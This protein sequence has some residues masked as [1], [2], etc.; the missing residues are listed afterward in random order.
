MDRR[1]SVCILVC[2][3][4][5][6]TATPAVWAQS[7]PVALN[8][9]VSQNW[10][11]GN[12]SILPI[13]FAAWNGL[14]RNEI[15]TKAAAEASTP[16]GDASINAT[17]PGA[18]GGC[19]GY[20]IGGNARFAIVTSGNGTNGV[21]QLAMAINTTG[22]TNISISYDLI[23]V[24]ANTRTVGVV[25]QYRVGTSGA[26][27]TLT[28]TGNPYVQSG[29][30]AGTVTHA[31]VTLPAAAENQ[32]V[33]Q[34]RW[35]V[36][37]GT[38]GGS[39]SAFAID[40]IA[41][42]A[43][44]LTT[45]SLLGVSLSG[46]AFSVGDSATVSVQLN[47]PP[48]VGNPATVRVA[49]GTFAT[50][51]VN[52]VIANPA[53]SGTASVTM[54]S[55]GPAWTATAT[56]V[57]GCTGTA[58]SAPFSVSSPSAPIVYAGADRAVTHPNGSL[59]LPMTG[60]TA[61]DPNGLNGL[62]YT[63]TP[64]TATGIS[65]W[66]ARTGYVTSVTS[67]S[68]ATV[69]FT[70]PG[71]Y[72][73]T[74]TV[75]DSTLLTAS[76]D[77]TI[78]VLA[79]PPPDPYAPPATYY[80]PARPGGNWYTGAALKSALRT[81]LN[82]NVRNRSY[83]AAKMGLQVVDQDPNN[84][85]NLILIYTGVSVPKEWDSGATWNRE[86]Q[87]PD[88]RLG[89][90]NDGD[91]FN[92]RPANPA[93]NSARGNSPYG[94]GNGYWDP[95]HGAPDRGRCARAMFYMATRYANLTL[96]N[97][98][99]G[100]EQMGDLAALLE[101]H[102][103]YPVDEFERRRNHLIWSQTDH[104]DSYQGN[105]NPYIDH[106]ELV[107]TIFGSGPSDAKI[108]LG[109]SAPSNGASSTTVTCRVIRAAPLHP[110]TGTLNN[111]GSRPPPYKILVSGCAVTSA[112][113]TRQALPGGDQNRQIHV[114]IAA[115]ATSGNLTGSILIDNTEVSSAGSGM[116]SNDG[117]DT[118]AVTAIVLEHA[119]ASFSDAS[120]QNTL[121]IDFGNIPAGGTATRDFSIHNLQAT[122]GLTAGLD[123]D[124][125]SGSGHT[126]LLTTNL[127]PFTNLAAGAA[128]NYTATLNPTDVGAYQATYTLSVSDENL[129]G[130]QPGTS[131]TLTLKANVVTPF[132]GDFNLDGWVD[133]DDLTIFVACMTGPDVP[134]NSHSL[135]AGC[136][137]MAVVDGFIAADFTKDGDVDQDDFGF[138]QRCLSGS[139]PP[140]NPSCA[141]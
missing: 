20:A 2:W 60:A 98:K 3:S 136:S 70:A 37:R 131:L 126:S 80:S 103:V 84:P 97:G 15:S 17:S 28:G 30:T 122:P 47:A 18:T 12:F 77:V 68:E 71:I 108:Y 73:L 59:T 38:E 36:W 115:T 105:R 100:D 118:I 91:L 109:S 102:Y 111:T 101:W 128:R 93:I 129:S 14:N 50:N 87:W 89:S 39:S 95:D 16:T 49:C 5:I 112:A 24:T 34:V 8:V 13:G 11:T 31:S 74:L 33:V 40:N 117:D 78:T 43:G 65:G 21:N 62:I 56:A 86:H 127:S 54:N 116:G 107:W 29:G 114:T 83:E 55:P 137:P 138:F 106:P 75:T 82:S 4:L 10:G 35:A 72:H 48:P 96:V 25:C 6:A 130:A 58:V 132:P 120:D 79:P 125:I 88:S 110:Q 61:D 133:A 32:P 1:T 19:Y 92:L 44:T 85:N 27:T 66:T 26:W 76:D 45:P 69:T 46:S 90:A 140:S 42:T 94:I 22:R 134:Y 99:P 123:L 9:P 119:D 113:G 135:P 104:P 52:I 51:P 67:P 53:T 139:N 124:A 64:A 121:T 23:S 7:N 41:V 81:I 57:S 141:D 63:W